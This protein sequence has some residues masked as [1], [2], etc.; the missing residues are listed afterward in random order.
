MLRLRKLAQWLPPGVGVKRWLLISL[1]GWFSISLGMA[2]VLTSLIQ[3]GL[4]DEHWSEVGLAIGLG[5]AC[6]L[7]GFIR[8]WSNV[9]AP[10][11]RYQ[12]GH[13]AEEVYF[14]NRRRRGFKFVA[15]GGGTGLPAT[16]RAMKPF[17][18]NIT[19]IVT[20]ADDGGS[21]GRLRRD[22]GV[23]PPGDLRNNIAALAD[24]ESLMTRLF[25][26]RFA[27]GDLGGHAFGNIFIAALSGVAG[28]LE[29]A[30]VE[31]GRVL[32]IQGRVLPSTLQDVNLVAQ[33]RPPGKS[34]V[35]KV[36]GESKITALGGQIEN[37][38]LYPA[39]VAAYNESVATI[40]AADI[41]VIGPGSLYTSLLPNL[42]V[43]GI[44]E[45]LRATRAHKIYICNVA[46]QPGE[47]E[48]Y[49]VADH[50][51]A[52]ENHIGR[53]VFQTVL[54]NNAQPTENAGEN[55]FYV[56][57]VSLHHEIAQRYEVRYYDLTDPQRPWR[58]D[59]LKLADAI[60]SASQQQKIGNGKQPSLSF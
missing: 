12:T 44:A 20:V 43:K 36:V 31:I 6:V 2:Y 29:N 35:L 40:L 53:G 26:Y 56:Q 22:L 39:D 8:F 46:T 52:L 32:N 50:V 33:V 11:R 19:A 57:P 16:L 38:A 48:A 42:L 3:P 7:I 34:R 21:S 41:V 24:D 17:T 13:L 1:I 47:T 54:A 51:L 49:D 27:N 55:T 15:I 58:H 30:L 14:Y 59:A 5:L 23:L 25:Q 28:G 37:L 18:G 45:A 10:Y 4:I 9:L 60:L